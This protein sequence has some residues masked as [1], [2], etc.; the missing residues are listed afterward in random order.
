LSVEELEA[1]YSDTR[2][3]LFHLINEMKHS[4]KADKPHL[5]PQKK[6]EIA[7][8]LTVLHEKRSSKQ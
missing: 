5:V 6:K 2:K 1:T 4:K 7:R 3:E 8:M